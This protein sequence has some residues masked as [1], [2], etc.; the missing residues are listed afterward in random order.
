[1]IPDPCALR[2]GHCLL[3]SEAEL[4]PV[5][6]LHRF[7]VGLVPLHTV[8]NAFHRELRAPAFAGVGARGDL[9]G[10]VGLWK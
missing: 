10:R 9:G 8:G 7:P 5:D 1:M 3:H 6:A 2:G 4:G